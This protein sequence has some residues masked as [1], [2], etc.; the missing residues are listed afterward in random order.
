MNNAGKLTD[1]RKIT[2]I[3]G[4]LPADIPL[5]DLLS[6]A[7]SALKGG[8]RALQL[9]DKKQGFKNGLKRAVALHALVQDHNGLFII[10]DFVQLALESG[11]DGVHLGREDMQSIAT[12]RAEAGR[13]LMIG[14]SCKADAALALHVLDGGANYVSFGAVFPTRTKADATPIG[15]LRLAKARQVFPEAC[16]CAIGG[17]GLESLPAVKAAG[18]DCAAV[19][20]ALFGEHNV[21]SMARRMVETWEKA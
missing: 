8:V 16:I 11:A 19:I 1:A 4:I 3:Y 5:E 12:I 7:E 15:L 10:N 20:S 21:E 9:R 18:A 2:G 17:I 13:A 14:V 6:G